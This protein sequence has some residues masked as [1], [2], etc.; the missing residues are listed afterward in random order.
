MHGVDR[1]LFVPVVRRG[2]DD[3]IDVFTRQ[4]LAVVAGR[5]DV[6]APQLLRVRQ[7]PVIAIGHGD[8]LHAR[9]LQRDF[10]IALALNT[11]ANQGK[12]NG[13]GRRPERS[14]RKQRLQMRYR[15]TRGCCLYS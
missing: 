14:L 9:H 12:M 4:N 13:V 2:N 10:R 3:G 15:N 8:E 11:R 5:E 1:G 7:P 6:A